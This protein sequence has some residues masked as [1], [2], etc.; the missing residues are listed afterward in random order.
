M[1]IPTVLWAQRTDKLYITIE[2]PDCKEP[3]T[4]LSNVDG[5][6]RL[7]FAGKGGSEQ[8]DY[9]VDLDF[10]KEIDVEGSKIAITARHIFIIVAKPEEDTEHWPRLTKEKH[11]SHIKCDWDKWV[12]EDE[13]DDDKFDTSGMEMN[14]FGGGGGRGPPGGMGGMGGGMGG[15][16]GMDLSALMGGMGGGGGGMGGMDMEQ[17]KAMMA[18]IGGGGGMGGMGGMGGDMGEGEE[19]E[20]DDSDNDEDLPDLV[21]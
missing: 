15:P 13:E 14:G 18:G 19:G 3:K 9:A 4:E 17:M 10:N 16:G 21:Q 2:V 7:T 6:G 11:Q 1:P 5:H 8:L 20:E 12:D